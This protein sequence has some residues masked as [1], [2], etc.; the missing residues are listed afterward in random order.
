MLD[1]PCLIASYP[2]SGSTWVRFILSNLLHPEESHDFD[3][4]NQI[5]PDIGDPQGLAASRKDPWAFGGWS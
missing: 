2:R 3:S 1:C 4:V 5:I